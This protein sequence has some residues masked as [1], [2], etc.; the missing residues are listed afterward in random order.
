MNTSGEIR[1]ILIGVSGGIAAYKI[2]I[3]VRL[4]RK[5]GYAVKVVL[6]PM[7]ARLVSAETLR[8]LSGNTVYTEVT[9]SEYD[10]GHISLQE[11]ADLFLVA[12]ATANTLGKFRCALADSL[13]T[14]LGISLTVPLL[15]APAMNDAMW[16][17]EGVQENIHAI[18]QR[19]NCCI[20]PIAEG[21]LACGVRG[22]GRM[23][24]PEDLYAYIDMATSS[25][26]PVLA[27]KRILITSGPTCEPLDPVRVLSNRSSGKMGTALA[28]AALYLGARDVVFIHGPQ[29]EQLPAGCCC[30]SVTT[31]QQMHKAVQAHMSSC[32]MGIMAAAVGDFSCAGDVP[33]EKIRREASGDSQGKYTLALE[34]NED[35]AA[36]FGRHKSSHQLL[37]TFS[38]ET[39]GLERAAEKMRRKNADFTVYN[40]V[41]EGLEGDTT[42][43]RLLSRASDAVVL[44][45]HDVSK[46]DAARGILEAVVS[47]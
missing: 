1:N 26:I 43:I 30:V 46:N 24:E 45:M 47:V 12:P 42:E 25:Y 14:T 13:L 29:R 27:G 36:W 5:N 38:L 16:A 31:A 22:A 44:H 15:F 7:G 32:D 8:T 2:P 10:M 20:L 34:K 4:L 33:S 9:S 11:W 39:E 17:N 41:S 6:S 3:L 37:I 18:S 35:I 19:H 40:T 21:E 23:V 28:R